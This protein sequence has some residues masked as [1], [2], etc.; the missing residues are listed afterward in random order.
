L[1]ITNLGSWQWHPKQLVILDLVSER[2]ER[3]VS[4]IHALT[5]ATSES[6]QVKTAQ[7]LRQSKQIPG[8]VLPVRI[9]LFDELDLPRSRPLLDGFLASDRID[10]EI[11]FVEPTRRFTPYRAANFD[12][13][14]VL[15]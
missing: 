8:D 5:V 2:S 10:D 15:C 14:S 11:V 12:P 9:L 7:R 3:R 1:Q 13:V 6:F 4:G